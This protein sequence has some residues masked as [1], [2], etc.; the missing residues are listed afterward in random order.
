MTGQAVDDYVRVPLRGLD[1]LLCLQAVMIQDDDKL[2][3]A[4]SLPAV[5]MEQGVHAMT[6]LSACNDG[7]PMR[8]MG[9][10]GGRH[11]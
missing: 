9:N 2:F 6:A 1:I 8:S 7:Y 11:Y 10:I 4:E 5:I 3:I